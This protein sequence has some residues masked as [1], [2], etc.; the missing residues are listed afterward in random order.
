MITD[1]LNGF[2]KSDRAVSPV[3]GVALLIAITVIL[4]A[5]IG[6]VVLDTTDAENAASTDA[7]M[8]FSG[9]A[10]NGVT[11]AHEGGDSIDENNLV[12]KVNGNTTS[13]TANTG[14]DGVFATGESLE[15][16]AA[17]VTQ[18]DRVVV[19]YQD[20]NSDRENQ[21]GIFEVPA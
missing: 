16:A 21:L 7:R 18:D 1:Q 8:D 14:G 17:D 20:P 4:A 15:I 13:Y 3:V 5:V 10:S 11:I 6:F 9:D 2:S 12:V 19:V